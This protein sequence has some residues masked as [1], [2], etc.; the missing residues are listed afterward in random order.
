[1][2]LRT[3]NSELRTVWAQ[4][5]KLATLPLTLDEVFAQV[6]SYTPRKVLF[7]GEGAGRISSYAA[8]WIAGRRGDVVVLDGANRF[9]P[10]MV[11]SFARKVLTSP[12]RLLKKIRLDRAFTCYQ[13]ATLIEERLVS[14]LEQKGEIAQQQRQWG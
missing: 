12:E 5:P 9:D 2:R 1:M 7:W 6:E 11:S 8:G 10:Y 14:L 4:D 13:M 3:P